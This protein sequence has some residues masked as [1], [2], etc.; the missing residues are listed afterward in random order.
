MATQVNDCNETRNAA[1][2]R[3]AGECFHSCFEVHTLKL[4]RVFLQ[5][6]KNTKNRCFLFLL[7]TISKNGRKNNHSLI[8]I[9]INTEISSIVIG[10]ITSPIYHLFTCQVVISQFGIEQ[11]VIEQVNRPITF[12]IVV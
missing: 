12:K 11:F 7:Q 4:L 10:L 6:G 9:V 8:S 2:A 5:L 3:A 1:G